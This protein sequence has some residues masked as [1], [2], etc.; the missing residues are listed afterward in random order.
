MRSERFYVNEKY[1][2][3]SWDR[4][5]DLP[6]GYSKYCKENVPEDILNTTKACVPDFVLNTSRTYVS[7]DILNTVRTM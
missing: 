7:G 6:I 1:T 3:T 4:T 2:D 5:S